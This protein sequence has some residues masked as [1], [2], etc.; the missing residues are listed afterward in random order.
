MRSFARLAAA[1]PLSFALATPPSAQCTAQPD[2]KWLGYQPFNDKVILDLDGDG[3][4]S[5]DQVRL[6]GNIGL[7][8]EPDFCTNL[9][10]GA[11]PYVFSFEVGMQAVG[12][13]HI[14]AD[15]AA[16]FDGVPPIDLTPGIPPWWGITL[17]PIVLGDGFFVYPVIDAALVVS[18]EIDASASV[19]LTMQTCF[20]TG[21]QA[22]PGFNVPYPVPSQPF[23][24]AASPTIDGSGASLQAHVLVSV[25]FLVVFE[26]FEAFVAT[27]TVGP[28]LE[29]DVDPTGTP[30]WSLEASVPLA[31]GIGLPFDLH[32]IPLLLGEIDDFPILDAGAGLPGAVGQRT[33][34]IKGYDSAPV[35][36]ATAVTPG[37]TDPA[38][39]FVTAAAGAWARAMELDEDGEVVEAYRW[40]MDVPQDV[41]ATDSGTYLMVGSHG[42]PWVAEYAG[43]GNFLSSR[44]YDSPDIHN[45]N[46]TAIDV[47]PSGERWVAGH[48]SDPVTFEWYTAMI[49]IDVLGHELWAKRYARVTEQDVVRQVLATSDGGAILVGRYQGSPL[50]SFDGAYVLKVD[51]DGEIEWQRVI[52]GYAAVGVAESPNGGF[53]VAAHHGSGPAASHSMYAVLFDPDGNVEWQTSY[54]DE[55]SADLPEGWLHTVTSVHANNGG[56]VLTGWHNNSDYDAFLWRINESGHTVWFKTLIGGNGHDILFDAR[57]TPDGGI[58][59]VGHSRS[60]DVQGVDGQH[61]MVVKTGSDGFVQFAD[62]AGMTTTNPEVQISK[63]AMTVDVPTDPAVDLSFTWTDATVNLLQEVPVQVED[64]T[65]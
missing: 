29:L 52:N 10:G 60:L 62:D 45:G 35:Q 38:H 4:T 2:G 27:F 26:G 24:I 61:L 30:W 12:G 6:N 44:T 41:V 17:P 19:D 31:F 54:S 34:W 32:Y 13:F 25:S 63:S 36:S 47:G 64:F 48:V 14:E 8:F 58:L 40:L 33:R 18:G 49:K 37:A 9:V 15:V 7:Y 51:T 42:V 11:C 28:G 1:L 21:L 43:G 5:D 46:A 55:A 20:E 56:Y 57:P 39:T 3:G 65:K 59:A 22:L 50:H 16:D 23:V 53:L